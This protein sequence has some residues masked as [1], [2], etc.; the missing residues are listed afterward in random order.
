M[1][2]PAD[3]TELL[4]KLRE[5]TE[6]VLTENKLLSEKKDAEEKITAHE[7]NLREAE[8]IFKEKATEKNLFSVAEN[9]KNFLPIFSVSSDKEP[10]CSKY[11]G[12]RDTIGDVGKILFEKI[13]D[14][15]FD[16]DVMQ[17]EKKYYLVMKW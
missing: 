9:G 13:R 10:L 4:K 8:R 6:K 7:E 2:I 14:H 15:G 1:S 17:I 16:A 11:T 12:Y 5:T 3:T